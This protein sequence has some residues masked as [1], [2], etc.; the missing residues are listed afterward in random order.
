MAI[1]ANKPN[2]RVFLLLG[3]VLAAL[4]FGGVL[5]ALRSASGGATKSV[6][7]AKTP[8]TAGSQVTA[9]QLT[10]AS[11]PE[12][13]AAADAFNDPQLVV[14]KTI[15]ATVSANTQMV[16]AL[17]SV[18]ALPG[19]ASSGTTANGQ[20][21][22]PISLSQIVTKGYV[23]VAIP[24]GGQGSALGA[25]LMSVG[26]YIQTGDHIDILIDPGS[27]GVRYSFQDVPVLRVGDSGSAAGAAVS[28][29]IVEVTRGQ[30]ELLTELFTQRGQQCTTPTDC[31]MAVKYVLRPQ[32]E[33]GKLTATSYEPNYE[34]TGAQTLPKPQDSTVTPGT[35][36]S[37]FGR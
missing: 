36:N 16:P 24:A 3:V 31:P 37:I 2:N 34:A 17:F 6:V 4:A 29:Y 20:A 19:P 22:P 5:F 18:A 9:D 10:T 15:N 8:I 12:T 32:S 27:G 1:Q 30:A 7:V 14:G 33:W 28:T 26:F 13:A 11:V 21:A 23:A 25:D 35:L